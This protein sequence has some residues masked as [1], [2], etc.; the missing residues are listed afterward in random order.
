MYCTYI[1]E[2]IKA[3]V[4]F[5]YISFS[6]MYISKC[7]ILFKLLSETKNYSPFCWNDLIL[8]FKS[9]RFRSLKLL[10]K[11]GPTRKLLKEIQRTWNLTFD[12][13]VFFGT[14][15]LFNRSSNDFCHRN[16]LRLIHESWPNFLH[17]GW[18]FF[19]ILRFASEAI[20]TCHLMGFFLR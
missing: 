8:G 2:F 10:R 6:N 5:S 12:D 13:L 16:N 7:L 1:I 17:N 15:L 3:Y 18:K 9:V 4:R 14:F 19:S 20:R 11:V